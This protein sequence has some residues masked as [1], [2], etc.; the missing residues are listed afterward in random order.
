MKR[1]VKSDLSGT[2][3]QL[4][5]KKIVFVTKSLQLITNKQVQEFRLTHSLKLLNFSFPN[6]VSL[7]P[8]LAAK[9]QEVNTQASS[10]C[11]LVVATFS[12][13]VVAKCISKNKPKTCTQR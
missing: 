2:Q 7:S 10:E 8:C 4:E 6:F 9:A 1:M 3:Y 13:A 11:F 12:R 5:K